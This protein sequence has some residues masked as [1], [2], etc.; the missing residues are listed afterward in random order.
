LLCHRVVARGRIELPTPRFSVASRKSV[1]G[2][3]RPFVQLRAPR[4]TPTFVIFLFCPSPWS[5]EWSH[6]G[7]TSSTPTASRSS[8]ESDGAHQGDHRCRPVALREDDA[9][10]A[11]RVRGRGKDSRSGQLRRSGRSYRRGG[12]QSR[13]ARPDQHLPR[14]RRLAVLGYARPRRRVDQD[15]KSGSVARSAVEE[16]S[17]AASTPSTGATPRRRSPTTA[18]S[19]ST[20]R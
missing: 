9:A 6:K 16:A 1:I 4:I 12:L 15:H 8:G 2:R 7:A 5:H 13:M 18:S 17:S 11:A 20:A 3:V 14:A 19:P 10:H